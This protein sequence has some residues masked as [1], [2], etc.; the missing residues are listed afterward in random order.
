VTRC[1]AFRKQLQRCVPLSSSFLGIFPN[2]VFTPM[3]PKPMAP[4]IPI[5]LFAFWCL[6]RTA[7]P[8]S[9]DAGLPWDVS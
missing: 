9:S 7:E 8:A 5:D 1:E 6:V 4:S 2:H 3:I